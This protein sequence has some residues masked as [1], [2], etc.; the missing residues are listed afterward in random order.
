VI[1]TDLFFKRAK[2]DPARAI[3]LFRLMSTYSQKISPRPSR[4]IT[5]SSPAS[6]APSVDG[7]VETDEDFAYVPETPR[8]RRAHNYYTDT[9]PRSRNYDNAYEYDHAD[10]YAIADNTYS[11]HHHKVIVPD[12]RLQEKAEPWDFVLPVIPLPAESLGA[13]SIEDFQVFRLRDLIAL[14]QNGAN[15]QSIQNYLGRFDR[16]TIEQS[17]ND[18]I[19]GFPAMFYV[20][21]TNK[22]DILR[23][24]V[25]YGGDTS[26]VHTP[27]KVPLLAFAIMHSENIRADTTPMTATLLSLGAVPDVIPTAFYSPYLQDL[28][29][30]GPSDE[31]LEDIHDE[32][33]SW[34]QGSARSKLARTSTLSQRY[35]L[36]RAAR[37]KKPS[38]RHTQ[39]AQRMK[40]EPLLG[41]A[42]FLI[43]QT[44]AAKSL[45]TT[46]LAHLTE[47]GKKPLVLV[48]AGPSG[49][50]KTELARRLGHLLSL[51]LEVV[52]CTI[53]NREMELFGPRHP[54]V[55]AEKG[56]PLNNFLAKN[57][58]QR[59]IV[60]LDE[61]EKT[62][63]DIHKTLL[64]PFESGKFFLS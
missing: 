35:Y 60:F 63:P 50:G 37:T 17:I 43:G 54:Y 51:E 40:A 16:V 10:D 32:K 48:F 58:E 31:N 13:N 28:P 27:S 38:R 46:L 18:D 30:H 36:D 9:R 52:D 33:K 6:E 44:A 15:V 41:I 4:S 47:P 56:T 39:V 1:G 19:E 57:H 14:M 2:N 53:F 64:L 34:C 3:K 29:E 26:A 61:F 62:S 20:V 11:T 49:H 55:G 45:L 5:P 23:T 42:N 12:P 59:C 25:A 24:W 8:Q 21:E 7:T 22:E